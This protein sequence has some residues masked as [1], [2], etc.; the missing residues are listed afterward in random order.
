MVTVEVADTGHAE[1]IC[2]VGTVSWRDAYSD[3]LP[4]E[5]VKANVSGRYETDRIAD[6]IEGG[7]DTGGIGQWLVA[8]EPEPDESAAGGPGAD[9]AGAI[10]SVV[11][12]V[13]D[14]RPEPG[15]GGVSGLY[16]H[17]DWQGAGVGSR[18]LSAVTERQREDGVV[19]QHT[20]AFVD[21]DAAIGFYESK[22][23][24]HGERSPAATVGGVD[25]DCEAVRL[26]RS[27]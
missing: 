15:V 23:F 10:E 20:Y 14:D 21:N 12:T 13:R 26:V 11:G 4:A 9:D 17:P 24:E 8:I 2:R 7:G 1:G 22:G 18:L 6:Q 25:P 16:V 19:E 27:I 3:V 5:Y